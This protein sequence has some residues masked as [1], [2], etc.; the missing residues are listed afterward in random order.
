MRP[1]GLPKPDGWA[2]VD[3]GVVILGYGVVLALMLWAAWSG[4]GKWLS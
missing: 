4:L 2:P 1:P 3:G